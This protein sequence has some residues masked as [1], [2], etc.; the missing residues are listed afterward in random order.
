[1]GEF[2][3]ALIFFGKEVLRCALA[4]ARGAKGFLTEQ[5]VECTESLV[6]VRTQGVPR[7]LAHYN[8][9]SIFYA[10]SGGRLYLLAWAI[11]LLRRAGVLPDE[12]AVATAVY[13]VLQ[14]AE[15]QVSPIPL[16]SILLWP[17][18]S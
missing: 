6:R 18:R 13:A 9:I 4:L 16:S 3:S 14:C 8:Y 15:I 2:I 5:L 10:T 11:M 17:G 7:Q 1:M 12:L